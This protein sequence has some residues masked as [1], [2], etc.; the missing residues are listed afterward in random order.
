MASARL[1][2]AVLDDA[3]AVAGLLTELGYPTDLPAMRTRLAALLAEPDIASFVAEGPAGVVGVTGV[4][5]E[6]GFELDGQYA[7]LLVL[8]VAEGHRGQGIGAHLLEAV[9]TWAADRGACLVLLTSATRR[10]EAHRFYMRHGYAQTGVRLVKRFDR[11][12][13]PPSR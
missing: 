3:L 11:P 9:E 2:P 10:A 6:H 13:A 1:R 12:T 8:V 4:R 7:R 5:L